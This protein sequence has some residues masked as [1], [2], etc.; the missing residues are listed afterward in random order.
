[1]SLPLSWRHKLD[2]K[3]SDL[4]DKICQMIYPSATIAYGKNG[5]EVT[6]VAVK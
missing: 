5:Y 6:F 2:R 1:M 3:L 4:P